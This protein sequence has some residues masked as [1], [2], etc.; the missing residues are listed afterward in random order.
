M[1]AYTLMAPCPQLPLPAGSIIR[2]QAVDP[3]TGAAVSGVTV[4][5]VV[6]YGE[7]LVA[8]A[9]GTGSGPYML[10]PGPGAVVVSDEPI[11]ITGGL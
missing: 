11:K 3:S 8:G 1:A 5:N 7:N 2:L 6:V 4:S 9:G 10:V